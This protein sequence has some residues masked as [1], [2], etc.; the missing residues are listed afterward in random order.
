[1]VSSMSQE[2]HSQEYMPKEESSMCM[3]MGNMY[4]NVHTV[5]FL[6]A[7]RILKKSVDQKRNKHTN[8]MTREY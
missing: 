2:S 7:K 8:I 1:M 5:F 4:K 6:T 3:C